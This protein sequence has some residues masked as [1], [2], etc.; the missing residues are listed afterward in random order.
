MRLL[1][2]PISHYCERARW[3]L[4][5]AGLDYR[6]EQHLQLFHYGPVRRAGGG[7][8][9]PVLVTDDGQVL[10]DSA[11][12]VV[13]ADAHAPASQRLYPQDPVARRE[14]LE[15]EHTLTE[16][17][18]VEARRIMY[19]HF[20]RWGRPALA[21]NGGRAPRYQRG[22]AWLAFPFFERYARGYLEVNEAKVSAAFE[23]VRRV[24]D[25]VRTRLSDGR[26]FLTGD[27]FTA[28]DLTFACMAAPVT[29][30][31]EYG[32]PLPALEEF[33]ELTRELLTEFR[34]HPAGQFALRMFAEH[35][36]TP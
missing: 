6:E 27:R 3:A 19:E 5:H 32:V 31:A 2:I 21:F 26:S 17:L 15:L 11:D 1:T 9:V 35:R 33:P 36:R 8:M 34:E 18:G 4:E 13:Y 29:V 28:A 23:H 30:P 7:K 16:P 20:F 22:L 12:I 10:T 25:D 14:T 24:F